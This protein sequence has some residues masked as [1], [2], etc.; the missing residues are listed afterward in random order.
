MP[1]RSLESSLL[2]VVIVATVEDEKGERKKG[3]DEHKVVV[4]IKNREQRAQHSCDERHVIKQI[5]VRPKSDIPLHCS[6]SA[7]VLMISSLSVD[8]DDKTGEIELVKFFQKFT[9][10]RNPLTH[11]V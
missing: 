5:E 7:A 11:C 8:V 9:R 6:N 4:M 3:N 1:L 2:R 10:I